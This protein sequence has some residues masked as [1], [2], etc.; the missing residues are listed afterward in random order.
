MYDAKGC[1]A[2]HVYRVAVEVRDGGLAEIASDFTKGAP[3]P[4]DQRT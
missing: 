1:K 2:D 3:K 4:A